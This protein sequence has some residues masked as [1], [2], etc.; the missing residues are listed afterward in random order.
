MQ[1]NWQMTSNNCQ[2]ANKLK[3]Q[4]PRHSKTAQDKYDYITMS[5]ISTVTKLHKE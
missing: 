5:T 2:M 3:F 1:N 4:I